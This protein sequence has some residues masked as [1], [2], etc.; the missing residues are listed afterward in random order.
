MGRSLVTGIDIGHS[1]I[2]AVVLKQAG[3]SYV[4]VSYKELPISQ[5]I[6]AE[7]HTVDHQETVKKL[8]E[9]KKSLPLFRRNIALAVPDSVVM[10]KFIQIDAEL[11]ER[12]QEFAIYQAFAHQSPFPI[13]D[14]NLDFVKVDEAVN[15]HSRTATYQVYATKKNV[16]ESRVDAASE[17]GLTPVL[18]DIQAHGLLQVCQ[19]MVQRH[20]EQV[21]WLILDIGYSQT[22]LCG[23]QAQTPFSKDFP[24]G[25]KQCLQQGNE[26]DFDVGTS[27]TFIDDLIDRLRRAIQ[28]H[29][30]VNEQS[31]QGIWLS[32]GGAKLPN[33][34]KALRRKLLV[35]CEILNPFEDLVNNPSS[36]VGNGHDGHRFSTAMG[37]AISGLEWLES[38]HVA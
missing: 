32:G 3:E 11:E 8:K 1:S 30:S 22:F 16:V 17:A 33:L 23:I 31:I 15:T 13:E 35:Q 38:S 21:N 26:H 37:L 18:I 7:N 20:P 27:N 25:T 12:E 4:L 5:R 28:M 34:A 2:K 10:S 14:L 24:M 19:R 9:L 6:F 36:A 29:G